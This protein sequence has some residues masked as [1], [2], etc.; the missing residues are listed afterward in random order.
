MKAQGEMKLNYDAHSKLREFQVGGKVLLFVP[1]NK[2]PLQAKYQ[3]PFTG[4]KKGGNLNSVIDTPERRE[5]KRLALINLLK[6]YDGREQGS[7]SEV[8]HVILNVGN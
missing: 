5:D 3:E 2:Y 7:R 8:V 6:K 4:L 1:D